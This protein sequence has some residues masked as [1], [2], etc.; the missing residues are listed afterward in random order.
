MDGDPA[1]DCRVPLN[2]KQSNHEEDP[3]KIK[4]VAILAVLVV[5]L[6][7]VAPAF[8]MKGKPDFAP[9]IY[10]DGEAWGTK[11]TTVYKTPNDTALAHSFDK[12]FVIT[13]GAEGQLPVGEAAP[14]NKMYNGGR[15]YTHT[16][17]WTVAGMA[18]HDP[19]PVLMSYED[20]MLHAGEVVPQNWTGC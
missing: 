15:W 4:L 2:E 14:G 19:L 1:A 9:H 5:T 6:A 16:V 10:A 7:V 12:L 11:V 3:M 18:A 8:A 13:N 17:M 20:V